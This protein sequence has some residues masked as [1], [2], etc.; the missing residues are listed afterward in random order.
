MSSRVSTAVLVVTGGLLIAPAGLLAQT[1]NPPNPTQS[2]TSDDRRAD[3]YQRDPDVPVFR[4]TVVGRS[5]PAINYR[6]RGGAT[7]ID[8]RG[9]PL[10]PESRGEAKVESKQGYIEI[11]V[12]FDELEPATKYGPE[13]LTYVMWAVTPEGRAT[14]LGEVLLNGTKSKL[15]VTTE[16]QAFGLIITAE[17]YFA[18]SQPSDVV[19]MENYVRPDTRGKIETVNARYDLLKRGTYLMNTSPDRLTA[20][21]KLDRKTPLELYEARNAIELSRIAG[22]DRYASDTWRRA[23]DLLA[24]AE[25][26]QDKNRGRRSVVMSAREAAQT[27]EDSRLIALQRQEEERVEQERIALQRR[28]ADAVARAQAEERLR[29]QAEAERRAMDARRAEAEA[30]A[31]RLAREREAAERER[32]DALAARAAAERATAEAQA[33]QQQLAQ[34]R[35]AA[36]AARLSADQRAEEARRLAEQTERD[37]LSDREQA[38]RE[39]A[40]LRTRLQQQLNIILETRESARGLIVNMSDVL[41]D[42]ARHTLRPGAR[43]KLARVAGI[44]LAHPGLHLEVEGHTDSV[45]SDT[46]NQALSERRAASVLDYLVQQGI[47]RDA[48]VSHGFGESTPVTTNDTSAGRQQNRRV[49]LVVSGEPIGTAPTSSLSRRDQ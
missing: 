13:Y 26:A 21:R 14:N 30:M 37:R 7:K 18:V 25:E 27:A 2:R 35:A 3:D 31:D 43:E 48:I 44:I 4:V 10:L 46:Y 20:T 6:H 40:E 39:K 24:R 36:E 32:T 17:P 16:L 1:S 38:E 5:T 22:A 19:V 23:E 9:T 8:F 29:E 49:E 12:E 11:E 41:F 47:A 45:G 34:E 42:T 28:E 33:A 15:N